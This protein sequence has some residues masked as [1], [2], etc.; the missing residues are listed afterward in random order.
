MKNLWKF[1]KFVKRFVNGSTILVLSSEDLIL[2]EFRNYVHFQRIKKKYKIFH[3][4]SKNFSNI[5]KE[6]MKGIME[7][8]LEFLST[9]EV[10]WKSWKLFE[11]FWNQQ[12]NWNYNKQHNLWT[13]INQVYEFGCVRGRLLKLWQNSLQLFNYPRK[14][15][16]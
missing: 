13:N 15:T 6:H 7:K 5:S 3:R 1:L 4:Y 11:N 10:L 9:L 12:K 8:W 14:E 16:P 2:K